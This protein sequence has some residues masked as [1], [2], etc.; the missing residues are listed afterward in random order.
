M[1]DASLF[2]PFKIIFEGSCLVL[3]VLLFAVNELFLNIHKID[4]T[5]AFC[6]LLADPLW[7]CYSF[8]VLIIYKSREVRLSLIFNVIQDNLLSSVWPFWP[9][10]LSVLLNL[11]W[12]MYTFLESCSNHRNYILM[13]C[14]LET[15]TVAINSNSFCQLSYMGE[16]SLEVK[17]K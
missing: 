4:E 17:E 16:C 10:M 15:I 8:W 6:I 3:F 12:V 2:L 5:Y 9:N 11:W 7:H 14:L 13:C 1:F